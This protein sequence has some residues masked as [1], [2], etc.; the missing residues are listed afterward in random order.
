[1]TILKKSSA[2]ALALML[3]TSVSAKADEMVSKSYDLKNFEEIEV[4]GVYE[5]DVDVADGF[6]IALSGEQ[7]EMDRVEVSV[8]DG[9]LV[10]ATRK[11]KRG[12][13]RQ[14]Q[15]KGV[16]ATITMPAFSGLAV[17][18]VAEANVSGISSDEVRVRLSGVGEITLTGTCVELDASVSGVGELDAEELKCE[19]VDV[20][21]SGVGEASV[22][23]SEEVTA[24]VSGMGEINVE[25]SPSKVSKNK[26]MF[27]D[28]TIR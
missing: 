1:M 24:K 22:Y 23:A 18:G 12:E 16:K 15:R 6:S 11:R 13:K 5:L 28:I 9:K 8:V 3:L 14:N 4:S 21:V 25:G 20:S 26:S 17:T 2:S 10:L 27:S 7:H 19:M